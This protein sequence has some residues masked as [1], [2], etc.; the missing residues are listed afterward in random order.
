[1]ILLSVDVETTGLDKQNDRIIELGLVLYS[2]KQDRV[3][4][5]QGLLVQRDGVPIT[6]EAQEKTGISEKAVDKFGYS[7]QDA[8]DIYLDFVD[9]ADVI[10]GHNIVRFDD[11]LLKNAAKRV[12][13]NLPEKL[14]VDT[15][16]DIPGVKGEKLVT[17]CADKGFVF[18][19]H[20]ALADAN[21]VIKL[22][23]IYNRASEKTSYERMV[24][25]AKSPMLA[26]LS[27]Q[28]NN[29]AEN[30]VARKAGFRWNGDYRFWWKA[31]KEMDLQALA[32]SVP[33][34]ISLA[35]K[36]VSLQALQDD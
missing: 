32:N 4:G 18:D 7:Q 3:L 14:L 33:F 17:M 13:R 26:V 2:D 23:S 6:A 21:A 31:A 9:Y 1:M 8:M 30:K 28:N 24:E 19:A 10:I 36:D 16:T 29:K 20:G 35:D 15:M 27:H 12:G 25:R 5:S 22:T 34:Q 11:H